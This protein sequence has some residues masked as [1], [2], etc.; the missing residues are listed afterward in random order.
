M[1]EYDFFFGWLR[2]LVRFLFTVA[3]Q[4]SEFEID[5]GMFRFSILLLTFIFFKEVCKYVRL[6]RIL[7]MVRKQGWKKNQVECKGEKN[8]DF[9]F[10][11]YRIVQ[12]YTFFS[13]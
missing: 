10:G 12:R 4:S 7:C 11:I 6:V 3:L 9:F 1:S 5:T 2:G 13:V 8:I